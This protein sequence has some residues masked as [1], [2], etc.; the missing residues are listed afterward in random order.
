MKKTFILMISIVCIFALA[1]CGST[2]PEQDSASEPGVSTPGSVENATGSESSGS[3]SADKGSGSVSEVP[4]SL[5]FAKDD[6]GKYVEPVLGEW[7]AF[8]E[9]VFNSFESGEVDPGSGNIKYFGEGNDG[10]GY[11]FIVATRSDSTGIISY[12]IDTAIVSNEPNSGGDE[13]SGQEM[14]RWMYDHFQE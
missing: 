3:E 4:S 1:S 11:C 13:A 10:L 8:L 9:K 6:S 12:N 5:V 7:N 14:V 2:A